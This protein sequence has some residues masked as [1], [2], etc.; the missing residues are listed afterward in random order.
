MLR[1]WRPVAPGAK[2]HRRDVV[3]Q[4]HPLV[5]IKSHR[6]E[7]RERPG[8]RRRRRRRRL[9]L[10]L[11]L[12][13]G[14]LLALELGGLDHGRVLQVRRLGDDGLVPVVLLQING[15]TEGPELL[16]IRHFELRAPD[17]TLTDKMAAL[18]R[19]L[20]LQVNGFN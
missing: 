7:R 2:R 4:L 16:A 19:A 17:G 20:D 18:E 1:L 3:S 8:P 9:C 12:G 11:G 6:D 15:P 13:R 5:R 14:D 10:G